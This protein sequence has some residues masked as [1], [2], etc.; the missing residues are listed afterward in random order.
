MPTLFAML[1]HLM[2]FT[3]VSAVG[4]KFILLRADLTLRT[5]RLL[6]VVDM[7][8]G[9]SAVILLMAG[10]HRVFLFEK[11]STYY[12]SSW[13]FIAKLV[14]FFTMAALSFIPTRVFLSWR[15]ALQ[16]GQVPAVAAEKMQSLRRIAHIELAGIMLIIVFAT[17]MARGIGMM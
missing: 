5:A 4:M 10:L 13:T 2:A 17:L 7:I 3:L 6:Q 14:L 12:F 16:R 8:A 15:D 11:G 9:I 1:H